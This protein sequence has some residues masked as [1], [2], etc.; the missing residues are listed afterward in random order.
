MKR[1]LAAVLA[2]LTIGGA[3]AAD[4]TDAIAAPDQHLSIVLAAAPK[5]T[6]PAYRQSVVLVAALG[7]GQ[8]GGVIVNRPTRATLATLFPNHKPS[9]AVGSPVYFGGPMGPDTMFVIT[10]GGRSPGGKS[11]PLG[12]SLYLAF[13]ESVIDRLMVAN[14]KGA[15]YFLG[16]I[17][18]QAGELREELLHG[19]WYVIRTSCRR[20]PT[21]CGKS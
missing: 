1:P 12:E 14:A 2:V 5:L 9:R 21:G 7:D 19:Y 16:S 17:Q 11:L 13:E 10:N 4:R 15:R 18:W 6:H 8:F 3:L 20:N